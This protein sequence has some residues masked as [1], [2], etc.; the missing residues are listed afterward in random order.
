MFIPYM[1]IEVGKQGVAYYAEVHKS[2]WNRFI[3]SLFMP[4]AATG[5]LML[6]P[7]L[8]AAT[9]PQARSLW[10]FVLSTYLT[11]YF[12]VNPKVA[13]VTTMIYLNC[14]AYLDSN[15]D[16]ANACKSAKQ[17]FCAMTGALL[18]QEVVGHYLG[19]DSPSRLEAIPNAILYAPYF[20]VHSAV[21][22]N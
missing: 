13:L 18:V 3:H 7:G 8:T 5:A 14:F 21:S 22:R 11:H 9:K 6:V 16:E 10:A 2:Q 12:T 1:G 17:G 20:A 19:G 4:V 15:Y